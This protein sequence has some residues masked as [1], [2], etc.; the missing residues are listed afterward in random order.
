MK[1]LA[2]FA[3][4]TALATSAFAHSSMD[5]TTPENGATLAEVPTE[6]HFSFA[7]DIRL[8]RVE[9]VY[10]DQPA[11]RLDLGDQK[12]FDRVFALPLKDEGDG[13]YRIEWRGLGADGHAMQGELEFTVD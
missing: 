5:T 8:T 1:K 3:L 10:E 6:I 11:I 7:N 2:A 12:S 13:I 4:M 9:M